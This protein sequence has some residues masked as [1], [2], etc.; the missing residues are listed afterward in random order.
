MYIHQNTQIFQVN[1]KPSSVLKL[2]FM[3][4][5]KVKAKNHEN[6][7]NNLNKLVLLLTLKTRT[8]VHEN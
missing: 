8:V 7:I 5:T 1:I 3:V 2:V 6:L 4:S